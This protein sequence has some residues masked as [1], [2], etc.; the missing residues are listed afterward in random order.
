MTKEINSRKNI[1]LVDDDIIFGSFL[2]SILSEEYEILLAKSGNESLR[3]LAKYVP[4]LI[5]LDIVMPEM[6][7]WETFHK[8]K[9]V[10]LLNDIPIAFI[11]VISGEEGLE[12]AK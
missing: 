6:D 5:L 4:D 11:T 7:G 2:V 3:I 9:G 12:Q 10:T 8:I 1:L